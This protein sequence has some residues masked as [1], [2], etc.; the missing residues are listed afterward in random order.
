MRSLR[1]ELTKS[2]EW[3]RVI[4]LMIAAT[5]VAILLW[6]LVVGPRHMLELG[7]ASGV[8]AS[9]VVIWLVLGL[10]TRVLNRR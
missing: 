3:F 8:T 9:S 4:A 10:A 5:G 6:K 2:F 1:H 7:V